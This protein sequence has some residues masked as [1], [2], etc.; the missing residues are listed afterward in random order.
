[1][2]LVLYSVHIDVEW[3][4]WI[5]IIGPF[6]I[7]IVFI[8][9]T[10]DLIF[11]SRC[12]LNYVFLVVFKALWFG[13]WKFLLHWQT[14]QKLQI[15]NSPHDLI[16]LVLLDQVYVQ[17]TQFGQRRQALY[18]SRKIVK[19]HLIQVQI[20]DPKQVIVKIRRQKLEVIV[21]QV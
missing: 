21:C 3:H 19:V 20:L 14:I 9:G 15:F 10:T 5:V 2:G 11:F 12:F 7:V 17:R 18:R 4:V 13:R 6:Q 16:D 8:I 1:M